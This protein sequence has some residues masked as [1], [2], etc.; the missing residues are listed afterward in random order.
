MFI[1][2]RQKVMKKQSITKNTSESKKI[3][4]D[5]DMPPLSEQDMKHAIRKVD[6]ERAKKQTTIRLS[7]T[8]AMYFM[9]MAKDVG[10]PY[11]TVI[12]MY[13]DDCVRRKLKLKMNWEE[14]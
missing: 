1:C 6:L 13:L 7:T 8:T 3:I 12:N 11:Q 14:K 5:L 9:T 2:E 4:D 10:L